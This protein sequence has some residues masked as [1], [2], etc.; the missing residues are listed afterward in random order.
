MVHPGGG[1]PAVVNDVELAGELEGVGRAGLDAQSRE[2]VPDPG[3]K[4]GGGAGNPPTACMAGGKTF[5]CALGD[6]S[7]TGTG[8]GKDNPTMTDHGPTSWLETS[9]PVTP[10][11][12]ITLRW[13]VYDS[14]DG[15]YDDD[16]VIPNPLPT[17]AKLYFDVL[18]DGTVTTGSIALQ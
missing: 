16:V 5:A 2:Q 15:D 18:V 7:L 3:A 17:D 1:D 12:E 4:F 8:F 9:A 6:A 10:H 14:G 13:S 11:G